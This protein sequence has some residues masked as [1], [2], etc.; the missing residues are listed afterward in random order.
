MA[1]PSSLLRKP[2]AAQLLGISIATF[3]RLRYRGLIH[4]VPSLRQKPVLFDP[5]KLLAEFYATDNHPAQAGRPKRV[6]R[7]P[8]MRGSQKG[9]RV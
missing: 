4:S 9:G 2:E 6:V 7:W 5:D 3:D 1:K 8:A